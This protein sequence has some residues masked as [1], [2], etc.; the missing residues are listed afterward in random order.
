[1]RQKEDRRSLRCQ[2]EDRRQEEEA[3]VGG[4]ESVGRDRRA[5]PLVPSGVRCGRRAQGNGCLSQ[6]KEKDLILNLLL[7]EGLGDQ[8][9]IK[10]HLSDGDMGWVGEYQ[11]VTQTLAQVACIA[12]FARAS[13][14]ES[15]QPY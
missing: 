8:F 14:W 7:G 11:S 6:G 10:D 2:T 5:G 9:E 4:Q 15:Y 1:M 13:G 3:D 12:S